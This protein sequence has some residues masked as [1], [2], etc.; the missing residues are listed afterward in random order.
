MKKALLSI[1]FVLGFVSYS[2]GQ[3]EHDPNGGFGGPV[4]PDLV[5]YDPVIPAPGMASKPYTITFKVR[6]RHNAVSVPA[7]KAAVLFKWTNGN[8][9][10]VSVQIPSFAKWEID[11]TITVTFPPIY[12]NFLWGYITVDYIMADSHYQVTEAYELNN[13]YNH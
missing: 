11:K 8:V 12:P 13:Q 4:L 3:F 10:Y 7:T 2:F 1:A 9:Q 6:N 5:I